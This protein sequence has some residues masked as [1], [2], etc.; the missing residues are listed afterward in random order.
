MAELSTGVRKKPAGLL[1][2]IPKRASFKASELK[3]AGSFSLRYDTWL[4]FG[5]NFDNPFNASKAEAG[6]FVESTR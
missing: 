2:L 5:S 6:I 1:T 4:F 3:E